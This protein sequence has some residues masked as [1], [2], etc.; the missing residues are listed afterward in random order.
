M[1]V[2]ANDGSNQTVT[3]IYT[4]SVYPASEQLRLETGGY[5]VQP[6]QPF[7]VTAKMLDLSDQPV[8]GRNLILTTSS[9]NRKSFDFNSVEQTLPLQTNAQGIATQELRLSTGYHE[10]TLKGQDLQGHD[11]NSIS[12]T[13]SSCNPAYANSIIIDSGDGS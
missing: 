9:W 12:G 13:V 5:F 2:T 1:E 3:G 8:M 6:G 4:F 10:L 11:P 7:T